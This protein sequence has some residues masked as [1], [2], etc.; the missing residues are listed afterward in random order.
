MP[1][2][3]GRAPRSDIRASRL[4]ARTT[5]LTEVS[6]TRH[7]AA[8]HAHPLQCSRAGPRGLRRGSRR[9]GPVLACPAVH[10]CTIIAKNYVAQA[11]V[12]ARSLARTDP[13][14]RLW[15]L[16]IDETTGYID[17]ER[18]PFTLLSP[19]DIGCGPFIEMAL[20][21][22]VLELSTAVKPWL[23]RHLME[24]TGGPVTYLDPD[25][26][27]FGSL[28]RL[29]E[30]A[31]GHGLVLTPHN[32]EPIPHDGRKPGQVDVMIAGIYNL[33]YVSVAPRPEVSRLLDW[34]SD[35]LRRDCRVDPVWGYFVDQRWFD[36]A[37]GFLS[38][39]SIVRDPEY[40]VAY[41]NLHERT[42][43][44]D[45]GDYRVNGRPLAFFHFSGFDPRH[46]TVLSR[47]QDR[48]DVAGR[49]VVAGILRRYA[50][51]LLADG[52]ADT[53]N[54]PYTYAA[55]A[56][57]T[58]LDETL[59]SLYD[60][61]LADQGEGRPSP[62]TLAGTREFEAWARGQA[63]GAPHGVSRILERLYE[64]RTDLVSAYTTASGL[65]G[66]GLLRWAEEFGRLE[67][68]H[69]AHLLVNGSGPALAAHGAGDSVPASPPGRVRAELAALRGDPPQ[70]DP[71][72]TPAPLHQDPLGVNVVGYFRSELGTG[73]AARAMVRALDAVAIP[74]LPV[75]GQTVPL[76]RQNH[77]YETAAP[78][79][80][81]FPVNLICMNGDMLPEFARQVGP[82]F[83]AGRY[84]VGLWF[85]EVEAFP[86]R[87]RDSFSLLEEV[88]APTAHIAAAL[89][90]L[91]TVPVHTVR[92]PIAPEVSEP[93]SR[94][95]LG[96][97]PDAFTFLFSF[98]YLSVA[99]RKNPLA[100]V[101]AF[102]RA[103]DPEDG[104]RLAIKCINAERDPTYHERLRA[105]VADRPDIALIDRYLSP[106]DNANLVALCDCYVSLHRAEGL[107]LVL[108]D[109]M[110]HGKPV[111]A[112]GYSGN[113]DFMTADNS[114]LVDYELVAIG[115]GFD[116]YPPDG[117]WAQPDV[118][119][120]AG[121]MRRLFENRDLARQIG[122]A[123]ADS[124]RS[125]H[126][127]EAAGRILARRLETIRATG[128]TRPRAWT[129][130]RSPALATL[131]RRIRQGPTANA[132]ERGPT[133]DLIR[134]VAMRAMRPFTVYQQDVNRQVADAIRE[135]GD[136]IGD[137]R[138]DAGRE[139]AA[140][141]A[142]LRA[143]G[144]VRRL[145]TLVA[146]QARRIT[147]LERR[148][149][150]PPP[151]DEPPTRL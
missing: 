2:E 14:S 29:H 150:A 100:T 114:V 96:L 35:R 110:W 72:A 3:L 26:E 129:A 39:L 66:P 151:G 84:S 10:V 37:P 62:F 60:D 128:R 111:I 31:A 13:G 45:D 47:H 79:D 94:G 22:S 51:A 16:V 76:S 103:F 32:T 63:P 5:A 80:A 33:G 19:A 119:Q 71:R 147:E 97:D 18:E 93:R 49:P 7:H 40:N 34:W 73:E 113:L 30:L 28:Q 116:P 67:E 134:R 8:Q 89:E 65:D 112:T 132:A 122:A 142:E 95:D 81:P 91:A 145:Q 101:A 149:D 23:L 108:A 146:D 17:A 6:L 78:E 46:P 36:L 64:R 87:W 137:A 102:S 59:R 41:W 98:D 58:R 109:A 136:R 24:V 55:L 90:P 120:A 126:S 107:G 42:L 85:W 48:I 77:P 130:S 57:G 99:E 4:R 75:H 104:A 148:L 70:S 61:Y 143:T 52:F 21:Y 131:P 12:L 105:V 133:R 121:Q 115:D 127:P 135:V 92:V 86:D 9:R 83:F 117:T 123:A 74:A 140:V 144:E 50:E 118:E 124:I 54:W 38:D 106:V 11:R 139:L 20:R 43:T 88:W 15:T 125:T 138:R 1:P 141:L 27:L 56:D 69:L 25:I 53:G 44:E 82:E 68:P